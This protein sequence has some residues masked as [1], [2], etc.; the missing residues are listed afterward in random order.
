MPA[1]PSEINVRRSADPIYMAH[2][3]LTKVPVRA[4]IPF[5]DAFTQPGDVVVDPFAGSGMTGVAAFMTGRR[6]VLSDIS[7][8][9]QHIGLNYVNLVDP[10]RLR[11][12][13]ERVLHEAQLRV[14]AL[15][16]VPCAHCGQA[17]RLVKA[18]WSYEYLCAECDATVA[19]YKALEAGNW[20]RTRCPE[21]KADFE[22]R[23][24]VRVGEAMVLESVDCDTSRKQREQPPSGVVPPRFPEL[25]RWPD[26]VIDPDREMFRR[27][28]LGK[29]GLETTASFFSIRN[30]TALVSLRHSIL[31]VDDLAIRN[32]L[33]F[34][35]T[36]ILP[37][38]SKR[39]Q[40]SRKRPLNA[41]NQT[42]YI[43]PIFYEWNVF[44]LFERKVEAAIASDAM[45]GDDRPLFASTGSVT[46]SLASADNL[47]HLESNSVDYVFTDPPF[48]SNIFYSDMNLFQEAWL[49]ELTDR[50]NEAVIP[51]NGNN[52]EAS[53]RYERILADALRECHRVL[54][55]GGWLSMVFSNSRGDVW[56]IAQRAI[57][58]SGL[59]LVPER[60]SSLDKGQRS[61]KG[62]AS[63]WEGVVTTD[64][65]FTARKPVGNHRPRPV[66]RAEEL[67]DE[68]VAS[69][70]GLTKDLKVAT[71]SH[72]YIGVVRRYIERHWDL[73]PLHLEDILAAL[74]KRGLEVDAATGRLRR[75]SDQRR[76]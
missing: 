62:L 39:Y 26:V 41:Q 70:V 74:E 42:Y 40:W 63:G 75:K 71:P 22:R 64:L 48:G 17:S 27:S 3:Y 59:E 61:V 4:I 45:V 68:S 52:G 60:L 51:T 7:R 25:E 18:V 14:P 73:E 58:D 15:Y 24:Q 28:A 43:A 57:K 5:L 2:G 65:V 56:G 47:A 21:C 23:G 16:A 54:K 12:R 11:H 8:L 19:Y 44:D 32:K 34:A 10:K 30:L 9:G 69:V 46:Y 33:L 6:A 35:L 20:K 53:A 49:G 31:G 38:A 29:H 36:A 76:S 50:S 37:R 55:P 72:V 66:K 13:A 1:L 67:V